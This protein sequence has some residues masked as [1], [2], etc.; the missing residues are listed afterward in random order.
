MYNVSVNTVGRGCGPWKMGATVSLNGTQA[1]AVGANG[2]AVQPA[3]MAAYM[4]SWYV[5]CYQLGSIATF[6]SGSLFIPVPR[7]VDNP[8]EVAKLLKACKA[9]YF[10]ASL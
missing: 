2:R 1:V 3:G 4:N 9:K 8:S 10:G 6:L 5:C 7:A